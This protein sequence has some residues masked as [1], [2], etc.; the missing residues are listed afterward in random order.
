MKNIAIKFGVFALLLVAGCT[1]Q[2]INSANTVDVP[3]GS[4][5]I[6]INLL[7][8]NIEGAP[9]TRTTINNSN[10][11]RYYL[12]I[13]QHDETGL[14]GTKYDYAVMMKRNY[15][16]GGDG[17]KYLETVPSSD[18]SSWEA[19]D[20]IVVDGKPAV[21]TT[22]RTEPMYYYDLGE[23]VIIRAGKWDALEEIPEGTQLFDSSTINNS[24]GLFVSDGN[25][26]GI[27]SLLKVENEKV[28]FNE[29]ATPLFFFMGNLTA[30]QIY[31]CDHLSTPVSASGGSFARFNNGKW[32]L[33][34]NMKHNTVKVRID[35][36]FKDNFHTLYENYNYSGG[37]DKSVIKGL[38]IKTVTADDA[39]PN[40]F[41]AQYQRSFMT[42][43]SVDETA[44]G[45]VDLIMT[46]IYFGKK[47]GKWIA[48]YE[49]LLSQQQTGGGQVA[50]YNFHVDIATFQ[51][52]VGSD[53][54]T[55]DE[56]KNDRQ[57]RFTTTDI[58][59]A[60]Y[61][62][63]IHLQFQLGDDYGTPGDPY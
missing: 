45:C 57:Y 11:D 8:D 54:Y 25:S 47:D 21:S 3:K 5:P 31:Q 43:S 61:G 53:T 33:D 24:T 14:D 10:I 2:D 4:V 39:D 22:P 38:S 58:G 51:F 62:D 32:L 6:N 7:N 15:L 18:W 28:T 48:T 60:D 19:Y 37:D 23:K 20:L 29:A 49:T 44:Y 35:V 52:F 1:K 42:N 16:P 50:N 56:S 27:S 9:L 55:I 41:D 26:Y 34:V 63:I 12:E 13:N 30:L 40:R 46:L 59:A 36:E 17:Y